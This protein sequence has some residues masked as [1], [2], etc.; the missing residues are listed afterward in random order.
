VAA[1]APLWRAVR[2]PD[3]L[4]GRTYLREWCAA[5]WADGRTVVYHP[6]VA[7]VRVEGDGGEAS[8]PLTTSA[9]QRVLDLRPARPSE[10]SDG[11]WRYVLSRDDVEACR[12]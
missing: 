10:L 8:I 4:E 11:A 5:L 2:G 7:A 9:W 3:V 6:E 12:G 1:V